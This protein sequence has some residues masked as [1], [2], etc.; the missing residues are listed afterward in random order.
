MGLM[1]LFLEK[2]RIAGD[3]PQAKVGV[4]GFVAEAFHGPFLNSD[5]SATL[6]GR[7]VEAETFEAPVRAGDVEQVETAVDPE[8]GEV[9]AVGDS[10]GEA[11][12]P[13]ENSK[14]AP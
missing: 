2:P 4:L 11:S 3:G 5:G 6:G 13:A 9:A 8:V 14:R 12:L 10:N 1:D 7:R